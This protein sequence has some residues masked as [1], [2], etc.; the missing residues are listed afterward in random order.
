MVALSAL[1]VLFFL[2]GSLSII[3]NWA[4][5]RVLFP[6]SILLFSLLWMPLFLFYAYDRKQGK[7][8]QTPDQ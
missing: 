6:L 2:L 4:S 5:T 8:D 1:V 3:F 7:K